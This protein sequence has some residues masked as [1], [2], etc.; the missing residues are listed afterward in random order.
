MANLMIALV[1]CAGL[2]RATSTAQEQ[3]HAE[4]KVITRIAPVYPALAR[5]MHVSGV[6]KL[7]VVIRANGTVKSTSVVGG[8]PV[9]IDAATVAVQKWRF[10]TTPEETTEV[11]Q[12]TF[13]PQ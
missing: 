7:A 8:A 13:P 5:R 10:E 11:V 1:F 9:L 12:L 3:D 2:F 6:V 4:R